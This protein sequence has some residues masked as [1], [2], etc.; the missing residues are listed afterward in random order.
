MTEICGGSI[1]LCL[2]FWLFLGL[3]GK[4]KD[5]GVKRDIKYIE[6]KLILCKIIEV[7]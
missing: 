7:L 5:E 2:L 3:G 6:K 4:K 1:G